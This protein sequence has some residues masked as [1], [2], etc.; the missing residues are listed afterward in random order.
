[1]WRKWS[2]LGHLL[3]LRARIG[4]GDEAAAGFCP[5]PPLCLT[6]SKKYCLKM[7]GSS[8]VPDLLETMK[9]VLPIS[10][11]FSIAFT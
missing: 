8:V 10:T 1:M 2:R 3:E 7:L 6:S 4:D 9:I 11:L 5:R